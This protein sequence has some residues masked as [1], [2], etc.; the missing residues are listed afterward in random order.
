MIGDEMVLCVGSSHLCMY[1]VFMYN[2]ASSYPVLDCILLY[3]IINYHII[4]YKSQLDVSC[5]LK[6]RNINVGTYST[7]LPI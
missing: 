2:M 5:G 1:Y 3:Y 4:Q 6:K 7:Q